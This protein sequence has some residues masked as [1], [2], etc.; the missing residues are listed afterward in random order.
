MAESNTA[1]RY[2]IDNT[3]N[4]LQIQT[5]AAF[6]ENVHK[7][8]SG[9]PILASSG[10]RS[11]ALS[12]AV[13]GAA[14]SEHLQVSAADLR[15]PGFGTP[16]QACRVIGN[17]RVAFGQLIKQGDLSAHIHRHRSARV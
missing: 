4:T 1:V 16:L 3:S 13:S 14:N 10:F 8:L 12:K 5:K 15:T 11:N 17:P 6:L 9:K 2:G 7:R